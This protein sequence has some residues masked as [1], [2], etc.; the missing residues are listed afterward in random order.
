MKINNLN[1]YSEQDI[2]EEFS[3]LDLKNMSK[4]EQR[5]CFARAAE[6]GVHFLYIKNHNIEN[7]A[8]E[9]MLNITVDFFNQPDNVKIKCVMKPNSELLR[10][11]SGFNQKSM[12][13]VFDTEN[14]PVDIYRYFAWG[15]HDNLYPNTEFKRVWEN[16]YQKCLA[17]SK[18]L[19]ELIIDYLTLSNTLSW[20]QVQRGEHILKIHDFPAIKS[21]QAYRLAAHGDTSLLTLLYQTPADNGFN[22]LEVEV[23]DRFVPVPAVNGMIL[24]NFGEP[25]LS[26]TKGQLKPV[27]HRVVNPK[28]NFHGAARLSIPFFLA[29]NPET[30]IY[31]FEGSSYKKYYNPVGATTYGDFL[32]RSILEYNQSKS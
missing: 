10:G 20:Q 7:Q 6:K 14:H 15:E 4:T 8:I 11:Y 31:Y 32:K 1:W 5:N 23:K 25:M 17:L 12:S 9:E 16:Y 13:S 27:I 3:I 22:S 24:L 28:D 26:L 21:D 30:E 19:L 18:T 2:P 29:V